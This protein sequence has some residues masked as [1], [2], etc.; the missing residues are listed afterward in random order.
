M[1]NYNFKCEACQ[2]EVMKLVSFGKKIFG[3]CET[4]K[5]KGTLKQIF[6]KPP[7]VQIFGVGVTR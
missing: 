2:K 4:Y 5:C 7:N 3:K 1:P 6:N